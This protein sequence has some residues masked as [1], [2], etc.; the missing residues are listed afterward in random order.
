MVSEGLLGL[1]QLTRSPIDDIFK[2]VAAG[3]ARPHVADAVIGKMLRP[4]GCSQNRTALHAPILRSSFHRPLPIPLT[5]VTGAPPPN[6]E[7]VA[8]QRQSFG[9]ENGTVE[10]VI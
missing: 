1:H 2:L 10:V 5:A 8:R 9:D 4:L 6:Q 3:L 7:T